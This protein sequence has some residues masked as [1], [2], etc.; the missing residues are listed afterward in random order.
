MSAVGLYDSQRSPAVRVLLFHSGAWGE[1]SGG[2]VGAYYGA[3]SAAPAAAPPADL[4]L[5]QFAVSPA[6]P[7]P[8]RAAAAAC[9]IFVPGEPP[10]PSGEEVWK[11]RTRAELQGGAPVATTPLA[12]GLVEPWGSCDVP[13]AA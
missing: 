10:L 4:P 13:V 3:L 1:E 9:G 7:E 12:F 5:G 11:I 2:G 6:L 8:V